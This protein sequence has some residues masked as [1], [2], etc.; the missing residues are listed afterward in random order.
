MPRILITAPLAVA[1]ALAALALPA[2]GFAT[3]F[4]PSV[5]ASFALNYSD[6]ASDVVQLWSSNMT[7]V[8][9]ANGDPVLSPFPN[10]INIIWIRSTEAPG[11]ENLTLSIETM[12]GI[13]DLANATYEIRLYTRL[14]N[15]SHFIVTYRSGVTVLDSN[16]TAFAPMNITGN[17]TIT[18]AGPNP[19]L[20]NAL[21]INVMKNLLGT[22][23]VWNIDAV[24]TLAEPTY[25]YR[26]YGWE[27][28]GNPGSG[29]TTGDSGSAFPN[30]LWILIVGGAVSVVLL[31]LFVRRRHKSSTRPSNHSPDA[32]DTEGGA[33]K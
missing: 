4:T 33:E 18:A 32:A 5:P 29:P 15:A 3:T 6:P 13:S 25:S 24:T 8:T 2:V 30:W 31:A 11:G 12:G 20:Q 10:S 28:P 1:C 23:E 22:I 19:T 26:D 21:R 17:S 9:D 16:D 7:P 14:D 27:V